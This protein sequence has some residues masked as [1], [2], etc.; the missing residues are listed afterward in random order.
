MAKIHT[1]RAVITGLGPVTSI[2]LGAQSFWQALVDEKMAEYQPAPV[3]RD[4]SAPH[5]HRVDITN[6]QFPHSVRPKRLDRFTQLALA[7]TQLA[8]ED[9]GIC[10]AEMENTYDVG[11]C[12]GSAA[13]GLSSAEAD[14]G[15]PAD[16]IPPSL[17][18]RILSASAAGHI[19]I[20]HQIHGPV[21]VNNNTCA[22]GNAAIAD[23]LNM[24][25]LGS[26]KVVIAGAAEA[27]LA[28]T[29][30]Q[31]MD[32]IRTMSRKGAARPF[33][34]ERDGFVMAEGAGTLIVEEYEHA[35]ARGATIYAEVLSA[36]AGCEAYHMTTP[37][38]SAQPVVRVMQQ[39]VK[40]AGAQLDEVDFIS[41]HASCTQQND[42]NEARAIHQIFGDSPY[43]H[44]LKGAIG[45]TLG[46][47]SAIEACQI[48]LSLKNQ[49][50][51]ATV[52]LQEL[53]PK[54]APIQVSQKFQPAEIHLA[55]NNAFGFGGLLHCVAF[56]RI[57]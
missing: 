9:A 13:G 48:C 18:F 53:D 55:L 23:A 17:P 14:I 15:Q 16:K 49:A 21:Q 5:C 22:A 57:S 38:P 44:G 31:A 35:V 45:H 11:I 25:R 39:A 41:A 30:F 36:G 1:S 46:A 24:I 26:A 20:A 40:L 27:P 2:G 12:Y 19:A 6:F 47:S 34:V 28:P 43:V 51:P 33:D 4:H 37:E 54:L 8:L 52:G 3:T 56:S 42:I 32:C 50:I 29:T 10:P 7:S